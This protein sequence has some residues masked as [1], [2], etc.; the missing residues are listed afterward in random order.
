M[1]T[2]SS[3]LAWRIPE[4]A[5]PGGLPSMVAQSRTRLKWLSSSSSS[6]SPWIQ[7]LLSLSTQSLLKFGGMN[8]SKVAHS[9]CCSVAQLCP[10]LWSHGLRHA[11]LPCPSP[12]LSLPKFM[13]IAWV[14][15]SS[16]LILWHPLLLLPSIFPSIRDFPNEL[17]VRFRWPKYWSFSFSPSNEYSELISLE[18]DWLDLLAV[19]G[20]LRGLL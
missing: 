17:A 2:H 18:I 10:T 19:Q 4:M 9:N 1:A 16:H 7:I 12:S 13:S 3:V 14:M 11:R 15:Q 5:G 8:N 20:T 6:S